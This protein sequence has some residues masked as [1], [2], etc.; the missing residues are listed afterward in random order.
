MSA[1]GNARRLRCAMTDEEKQLWQALRAGRFA[2]FKFRRQHPWGKYYLDFFCPVARLAVELDG[3]HHGLPEQR[4]HDAE[5][6]AFITAKGI[7]V[8]RFWNRQ[9]RANRAGILLEIWRALHERAGCVEVV[10]KIHNR[11]F[12]PPAPD[13]FV[14]PKAG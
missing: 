7:V 10:R 13:Q 5:R 8:L 3:F 1:T 14:D 2:G 4:S 9:W 12:L 11:R 6:E